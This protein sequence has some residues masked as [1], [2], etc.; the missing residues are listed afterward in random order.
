MRFLIKDMVADTGP[1][2]TF[3]FWLTGETKDSQDEVLSVEGMWED[4]Q[5]WVQ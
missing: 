1:N 5:D 3:T 4:V 2:R